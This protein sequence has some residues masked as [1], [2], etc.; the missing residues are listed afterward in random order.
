MLTPKTTQKTQV[1]PLT[2]TY[3]RTLPNIK[4]IT[5]NQW[6]IMKTNKALEKTFSIETII[7]FRENKSLKQVIEG[8]TTQNDKNIKKS[9]SR[10]KRKCTPCKS[11]IQSFRSQQNER[12]FNIF[13]QI[14]LKSD[15]AIYFLECHKCHITNVSKAKTN[16]NL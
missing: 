11:G 7:T 1:L 15:F 14:D 9:S 3:D 8:N 16:F 6:F 5:R 13:H 2:G 10:Y 12:M 4:Q